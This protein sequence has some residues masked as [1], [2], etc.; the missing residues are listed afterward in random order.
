M[1]VKHSHA[2]A[3]YEKAEL[4]FWLY[5]MT[6]VILFASLFA[7]YMILRPNIA[8]GE[9]AAGLFDPQFALVET[10]ILLL[11]S[12]TCGIAVLL[13]RFKNK[14]AGLAMLWATMLLGGMFIA[15]ELYEFAHLVHEG[16]SWRISGFLSSFFVLVGTHG[17]HIM[18]GLIWGFAMLAY[19]SKNGITHNS[20]R[21]IT[22][23]SLFWHFLDLV[24]IFI[25]TI[26][27]LGAFV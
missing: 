14:A 2:I 23:F 1:S 7:T 9:S 4:G 21:K 12:F 20:M 5:L 26:V 15:L 27:Y 8:G 3:K 10:I 11:S 18:I 16:Q 13:L 17:L 22:L 19:I 24:W 6:D 25:F